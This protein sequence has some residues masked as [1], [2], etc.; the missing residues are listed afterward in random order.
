MSQTQQMNMANM[1]GPVGGPQQ[2]NVGTPNVAG[3][4][5]D[6]IKRLNTA[7]Y[8]HLLRNR[9]YETARS[10]FNCV[11]IEVDL[12]KSPNQRQGQQSN[13]MDDD[14]MDIDR[15][16][17][18]DLPAPLQL[19]EGAFLEGWWCQFWEIHH[20]QRNRGKHSQATMSYIGAQRQ[21]QKARTNIMAG[22][23]VDPAGMQNV[24]GYNNM[25]QM[26][27]GMGMTNDLKKAA[28]QNPRNM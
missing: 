13:G 11:D 25:M 17:P 15:D 12:K 1:G 20:A 16:R 14:S 3:V 19:G 23:N 4:P 8:D 24:R 7:I 9:H 6:A 18:N 2:M 22:G 27:N 21:V 26:N 5:P 28:M 10:F